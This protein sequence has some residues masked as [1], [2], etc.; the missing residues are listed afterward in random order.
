MGLLEKRNPKATWRSV[1][2][3]AFLSM[4]GGAVFYF[5]FFKPEL[6][7]EWIITLPPWLLWCAFVGG[8]MEWQM[9]PDDDDFPSPAREKEPP[10]Q[11]GG[12]TGCDREKLEP[13]A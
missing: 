8:L 9:P 6:Q 3:H 12:G 5:L 2:L 7:R 11:A 1:L 4:G 10:A 13:P